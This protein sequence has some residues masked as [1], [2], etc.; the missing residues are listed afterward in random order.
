MTPLVRAAERAATP[1]LRP[2]L[3]EV[4]A[5]RAAMARLLHD[6]VMQTL[7]T[8]RWFAEKAGDT[9]TADAVR[10]AIAE[11]GA[12]MWRL[13]PRTADGHL[14]RALGELA[15]RHSD[16][17]VALRTDGVP[18]IIDP[19]AATIAFRVVQAALDASTGETVDV[20]V[21]VAGG[22][23]TVS[24]CDDGPAYDTAL[25]ERDSELTRWLARAGTVGGRAR[26]GDAPG[27]GTTLC[28]EI[29]TALPKE[30]V[31]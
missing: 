30:S 29:P 7:I 22:M 19:D 18:E 9:E 20:R 11:A 10:A 12:A 5:E 13:R 1:R 26:V 27:G 24:V 4:E 17:V 3:A 16:R 23:L 21:A 28:L 8:A 31:A 2:A 25:H 15:D 14:V 6:D